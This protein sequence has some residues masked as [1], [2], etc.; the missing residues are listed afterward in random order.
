L[1]DRKAANCPG[2][3]HSLRPLQLIDARIAARQIPPNAGDA[4][5]SAEVMTRTIVPVG[6]DTPVAEAIRMM[7]ENHIGG[8]PV[9]DEVGRVVGVLTEGDLL[10]RNETG[11]ERHRPRWLEV[12]MGPGRIAGAYTSRR[13]RAADGAPV[14]QTGAGARR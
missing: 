12:L 9:M 1:S 7:L 13:G 11:T 5:E 10:R 14:H 6:R 3:R 4:R 2:A 8:L